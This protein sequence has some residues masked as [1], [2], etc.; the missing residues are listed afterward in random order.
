M[1]SVSRSSKSIFLPTAV[2]PDL[3]ASDT[4]QPRGLTR[5]APSRCDDKA[6]RAPSV[7][8][9]LIGR[10]R[11]ALHHG[12]FETISGRS[13][14]RID[15][16]CDIT[17][18]TLR[19]LESKTTIRSRT[20]TCGHQKQMPVPSQAEHRAHAKC[21]P[22]TSSGPRAPR[23][24][25]GISPDVLLRNFSMNVV[26]CYAFSLSLALTETLSRPTVV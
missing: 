7:S 6:G 10:R 14:H 12:S 5:S 25:V 9:M 23:D 1:N 11:C 26:G 24:A 21:P 4:P 20:A 13:V 15:A 18:E 8:R 16:C 3:P 22:A 19:F 17:H 2:C